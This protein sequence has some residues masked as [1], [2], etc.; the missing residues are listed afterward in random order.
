MASIVN[1]SNYIVTVEG[2]PERTRKFPFNKLK[3]AKH[4]QR[5]QRQ[6][7]QAHGNNPDSVQ[8]TQLEDKLLV[9][10]RDKGYPEVSF[11]AAS[12]EEA[13]QKILLAL[14]DR[15]L[16][17]RI[18]FNKA[19]TVTLA[20]LF[21]R[22]IEEVCPRHKGCQTEIYILNSFLEDVGYESRYA[23]KKREAQDQSRTT[24]RHRARHIR[25]TDVEWLNK[26]LAD[27]VPTD[28]Q[29]Y[30]D[31]RLKQGIKPATID[32]EFDLISQVVNW[33]IKTLR[34]HL[35][36]SPFVGFERP[37]YF[38]ER[39]R[40]FRGDEGDRLL[41]AVREED[42]LR[43]FRITV[44]QELDR[45][46]AQGAPRPGKSWN[47]YFTMKARKQA[48]AAVEARGFLIVPFWEALF[49]YLLATTSRR[50]EALSLIWMHVYFEEKTAYYPD[51]KNGR[52]RTVPLRQHV[53]ELL[54][55]LPRGSDQERVFPITEDELEGAWTRICKRA[56]VR[57]FHMHDIRHEGLS[58]AA[59]VGRAAGMPFDVIALQKLSGQRD[60]RMLA[61]YSHLCAGELADRLDEAFE[62]AHRKHELHKGRVRVSGVRAYAR[63]SIGT[64]AA[65]G[66][67]DG[68]TDTDDGCL[69]D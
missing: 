35:E 22:Y 27:V 37:R 66:E 41:A 26:K 33:A 65:V 20:Q 60:L 18:D 52:S 46:R 50:S 4:Y 34:Y 23:K 36:I 62:R 56:G 68:S 24:G 16:G 3:E 2:K 30:V 48:R 40:R 5:A 53:V 49:E 21:D 19:R 12:Y 42:R 32:R 6:A 28:F 10:I 29:R 58:V 64:T 44:E 55:E 9:R 7:Q 25:R 1:R 47:K 67:K 63:P 59:E 38:N 43:S 54:R 51:T 14:A 69:N 31:A 15:A 17:R 61:R 13:E 45:I 57:D 11:K 39:D 8:L